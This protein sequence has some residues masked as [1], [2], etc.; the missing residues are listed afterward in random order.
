LFMTDK[1]SFLKG[2]KQKRT[3]TKCRALAEIEATPPGINGEGKARV[4][5]PTFSAKSS[6]CPLGH[7]L[8]MTDKNLFCTLGGI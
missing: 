8:F 1:N 6:K 7:F 4:V 5:N 3:G 2:N